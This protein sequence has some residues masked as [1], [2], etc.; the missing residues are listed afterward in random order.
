MKLAD[1]LDNA[2]LLTGRGPSRLSAG[3]DAPSP[4]ASAAAP[5]PPTPFYPWDVD[6]APA[7]GS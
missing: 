5:H 4:A 6:V 2:S 3:A 7:G 1:N